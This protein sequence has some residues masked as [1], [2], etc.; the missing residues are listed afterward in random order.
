VRL[1]NARA[2]RAEEQALLISEG[3]AEY[4]GWKFAERDSSLVRRV[5]L[6]LVSR[7]PQESFARSFAYAAAP[8]YGVLLDL[9][10]THWRNRLTAAS[11]LPK[12]AAEAYRLGR[13]DTTNIIA[14]SNRYGGV[15][16]RADELEQLQ[17]RAEAERL[18]RARFV[19]GPVLVLPVADSFNY[20]FNPNSAFPL[21]D[22]GTVYAS[23]QVRDVWGSLRV[24]RDGVLLRRAADGRIMSVVVPAPRDVKSP[25][26]GRGWHLTLS[27]GWLVRAGAR[28]G[29]WVVVRRDD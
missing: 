22:I 29:D 24:T 19:E 8:A 15:I 2:A 4:T 21:A 11:D 3:L 16:V 25:L 9:T 10:G 5:A 18:Y 1:A 28:S 14:R 7:E 20:S 17:R 26:E 6:A 13:I 27:A 12:L 23:S